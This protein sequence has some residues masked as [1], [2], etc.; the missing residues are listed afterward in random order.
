MLQPHQRSPRMR[1]HIEFFVP[2]NF[3]LRYFPLRSR[4]S[5]NPLAR[6]SDV[7]NGFY[8]RI[9]VG[10]VGHR[11]LLSG[12][13][14]LK[15]TRE[16]KYFPIW[17]GLVLGYLNIFSTTE[18]RSTLHDWLICQSNQLAQSCIE[19]TPRK[20]QSVFLPKSEFK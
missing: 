4:Q 9:V 6:F 7:E 3:F 2:P 20:R 16:A 10:S 18:T 19:M 1:W 8:F 17:K 11:D 14:L 13:Q 12:F 15:I 5:T